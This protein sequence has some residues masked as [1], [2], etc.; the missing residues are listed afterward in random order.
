MPE[1]SPRRLAVLVGGGLLV[2]VVGIAI[3]GVALAAEPQVV[4]VTS[5][6][7]AVTAETSEIE[8][9]AL[10]DNPNPVGVPPVLGIGYRVSMNEVVVAR[11]SEGG[12]GISPGTNRL[13]FTIDVRN[14]LID[15]WWVTHL[16]GGERSTLTI[17][18]RIRAPLGFEQ[19]LPP[20]RRPIETDILE[21]M[22]ATE[23]AVVDL[24]EAPFLVIEEQTA[25][26]ERATPQR[27]PVTVRAR[28]ANE[29]TAP[30]QL[31]GIA[32]AIRMNDVVLGEG[33]TDE[34]FVVEPGETGTLVVTPVMETP[35]IV[36]WWVSHLRNG[37]VTT[38]SVEVSGI[39]TKAGN[40]TAVPLDFIGLS[41]VFRTDLLGTGETTVEP[42]ASETDGF[43]F[44]QPEVGAIELGWGEV[45]DAVT[46]IEATVGLSRPDESPFLDLASLDLD[47]TV[48]INGVTV[49]DDS[50]AVGT[51]PI[52]E[53]T[54]PL[55]I[56]LD[57][58]KVPEW[59]A[60]HLNGGESS[61]IEIDTVATVDV[62]MTTFPI[63]VPAEGRSFTTDLLSDLNV[64]APRHVERGGSRP[65]TVH[66]TRA[67]WGRAT[68][69][70]APVVVDVDVSN[71]AGA[72]VTISDVTYRVALNDVVLG[73]GV[74]DQAYTVAA[75]T[76]R[77]VRFLLVLDNSKMD[78]WWVSHIR[79]GE[80]TTV[81]VELSATV[82]SRGFEQT[83]ALDSPEPSPPIETDILGA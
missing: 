66:R 82:R 18:T 60:A 61:T 73:D 12:V 21:P 68:P 29:H 55:L 53:G 16:N 71:R 50:T 79:N 51:A 48:R 37:E 40:R 45:T 35:L 58:S 9:V 7:G 46:E 65:L 19:P 67:S 47:Q 15:D 1:R 25:E 41:S 59:W 44:S 20:D 69:T 8:V 52:R 70:R 74:L 62:G 31:D 43:A 11:G 56:H 23:P 5:N 49:A 54:V 72:P 27:M 4:D 14:D 83:V 33:E 78:E 34:G 28:I 22:R 42:V 10:I 76:D 13:A 30:I 75:G 36:D 3:L 17:A 81:E 24:G 2:A 39:V 6:W 77:T 80:R 38:M 57:N 63:D 64:D 26:W 32:Y